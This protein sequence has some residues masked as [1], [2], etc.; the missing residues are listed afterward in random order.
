MYPQPE[1]PEKISRW[2]T[3]S[4]AFL[5]LKH[6]GVSLRD[7]QLIEDVYKAIK[8]PD[9]DSHKWEEVTEYFTESDNIDY[10]SIHSH[11]I[12]FKGINISLKCAALRTPYESTTDPFSESEC[13]LITSEY[14]LQ[15][16]SPNGENLFEESGNRPA[17]LYGILREKSQL[18]KGKSSGSTAKE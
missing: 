18:I 3:V 2:E 8:T 12:C 9:S 6:G 10:T 11:A 14:S 7:A 4:N 13:I 15:I 17:K 1:R 16:Q 5:M